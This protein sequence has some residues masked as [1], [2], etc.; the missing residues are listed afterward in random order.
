[1][2]ILLVEP[3]R[4]IDE[5]TTLPGSVYAA[6]HLGLLSIA[7]NIE[8]D[9]CTVDYF[10]TNSY[11]DPFRS[12]KEALRCGYDY[13]GLSTIGNTIDIQLRM[14]GA[15]KECSAG[16]KVVLGGT[17]AWLHPEE[18]LEDQ[19]VDFVIRG[20]GELPLLRL[21]EGQDPESI[22]GLCYKRDD[23]VVLKDPYIP[24]Q[25]EL[26]RLKSIL[27]YSKYETVYSQVKAFRNQRQLVTSF[28][29]PFGCNFCAVPKLYP[30]KMLFREIKQVLAEVSELSKKTSRIVFQDPDLNVDKRHFIDLFT[31]ILDGKKSGEIRKDVKF[32]IQARID[33]FDNEMLDLARRSGARALIGIESLSQKVR[34]ADLNKGGMLA[35]MSKEELTDEIDRVSGFITVFP[36]FILATPETEENDFIDILRYIQTQKKGRCEV[37]T[38]VTPFKETDYFNKYKGSELMISRE[39]KTASRTGSIPEWLL[40]KDKRVVGRIDRA[41]SVAVKKCTKNSSFRNIFLAALLEDAGLVPAVKRIRDG[42]AK[43]Y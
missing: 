19:N 2:R 30:R 39:Y 43:K 10:S 32:L 14:A 37:N 31:A 15:V 36:Y 33:C 35:S 26:D 27:D 9:A 25:Y 8:S 34:D 29:C 11:E 6:P 12:L 40:C 16:T 18:I 20:F 23:R 4:D 1:M 24:D 22:L 38:Y 21:I 17:H 3:K 13:V 41:L 7:A 28:G 42:K 5:S